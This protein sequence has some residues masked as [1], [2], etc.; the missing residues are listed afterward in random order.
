MTLPMRS[1]AKPVMTEKVTS[2]YGDSMVV[3]YE[4]VSDEASLL[5]GGT[6]QSL[7]SGHS[8]PPTW[9]YNARQQRAAGIHALDTLRPTH[10]STLNVDLIALN[11][12]FHGLD[13]MAEI[14]EYPEPRRNELLSCRY[15]DIMSAAQL[16]FERSRW[17]SQLC[18]L[19]VLFAI[20]YLLHGMEASS[21]AY[22]SLSDQWTVEQA[23][24]ADSLEMGS[25]DW[26]AILPTREHANSFLTSGIVWVGDIDD[27][28]KLES[29]HLLMLMFT[30]SL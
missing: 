26:C 22:D 14:M 13:S 2:D 25:L 19:Y 3:D 23:T 5:L 6:D 30:T 24:A 1:I 8:Q 12:C 16:G 17:W 18:C 7:F 29:P 9:S 28:Q 27:N 4:V 20:D 11:L 21:E 15:S 10:Q